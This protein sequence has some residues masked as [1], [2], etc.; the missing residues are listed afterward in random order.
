MPGG[1][2]TPVPVDEGRAIYL[3]RRAGFYELEAGQ[4]DARATSGFAA[5]LV[6]ATESDIEPVKELKVGD[7]VAGEVTGFSVGVR[8][9]VWGYLIALVVAISAIEWLLYHRRVTV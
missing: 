6:D 4:D 7:V 9:E 2:K 1:D 8:R 3:G 5:N